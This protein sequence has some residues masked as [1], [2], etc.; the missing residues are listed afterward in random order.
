MITDRKIKIYMKFRGDDDMWARIASDE[1]KIILD[2]DDWLE[3][4]T[5]RMESIQLDSG[6][7]SQKYREEI[8]GRI[9][10]HKCTEDVLSELKAMK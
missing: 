6:F 8:K 1:D 4:S 10:S 7:I 5:L 3:I 9:A 2:G